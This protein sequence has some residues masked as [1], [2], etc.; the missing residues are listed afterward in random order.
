[1]H[2][3]QEPSHTPLTGDRAVLAQD[4]SPDG[5]RRRCARGGG[6]EMGVALNVQRRDDR[7]HVDGR[8]RRRRAHLSTKFIIFNAISREAKQ[9]AYRVGNETLHGHD[10]DFPS[11]P[12]TNLSKFET[13]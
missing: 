7:L 3:M 10:F 11:G 1:M 12:T 2:M 4:V 8:E 5:A 9:K 6:D 13:I